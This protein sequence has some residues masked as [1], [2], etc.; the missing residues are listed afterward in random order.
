MSTSK[1]P[2]KNILYGALQKSV[3][4]ISIHRID[5]ENSIIDIDYEKITKTILK[6]LSES[7]YKIIKE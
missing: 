6:S 3:D 4:Y 5:R 1:N 7:G 2:V